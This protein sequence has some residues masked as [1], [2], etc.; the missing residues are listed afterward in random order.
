[1]KVYRGHVGSDIAA[2]GTVEIVILEAYLIQDGYYSGHVIVPPIGDMIA[3]RVLPGDGWWQDP[4][5]AKAEIITRMQCIRSAIS[6]QI[7]RLQDDL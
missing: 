6:E 1:M 3:P 5:S 7:E 4:L 2:D